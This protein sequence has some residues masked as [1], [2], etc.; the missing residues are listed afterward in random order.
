MLI[1]ELKEMLSSF[2]EYMEV[3]IN[4]EGGLY[5]IS[6]NSNR[7][8]I[9]EYNNLTSEE[10]VDDAFDEKEAVLMLSIF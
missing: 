2:S 6:R 7:V 3:V 10:F 1:K 5:D 9:D 4:S 8:N